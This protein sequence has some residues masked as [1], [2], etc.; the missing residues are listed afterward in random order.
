[1]LAL[2]LAATIA[3]PLFWYG[4]VTWDGTNYPSVNVWGKWTFVVL[5]V[6][7]VSGLSI[8]L[9]RAAW[10]V[11][12]PYGKAWRWGVAVT[13]AIGIAVTVLPD[14]ITEAGIAAPHAAGLQP[15][16]LFDLFGSL[17]FLLDWLL[18]LL[19]LLVALGLPTSPD[20]R[21][22]ARIL[23]I[24]IA[25]ELF[26]WNFTWLYLP[27]EFL[28]GILLVGWV[29]LPADLASAI[30]APGGSASALRKAITRWQGAEF[31]AGQR[32]GLAASG[33]DSLRDLLLK[34]DKQAYAAAL[35][36]LTTG[37]QE[38]AE[39]RA[40]YQRDALDAKAE[41][42][43]RKGAPLDRKGARTGLIT[44]ALLGV[45][46]ATVTLITTQP[47]DTGSA[48]PVLN[49]FGGTAWSVAVWSLDGCFIG[50]FLPLIRG[51]N[52]VQKALWMFAVAVTAEL[53]LDVIWD[54]SHAWAS[55]LIG[56]LEFLVFM[57]V[58]TVILDD[59][60]V[61][62]AAGMRATDWTRVHNWRFVVTWSTAVIAAIGT[63]AATFLSTA[64]TDFSH[65]TVTVITKQVN[66]PAG[67]SASPG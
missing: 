25:V 50:Y 47:A 7:T 35:S 54:D 40:A 53:P 51:A 8:M 21:P 32:Q 56:C 14:A 22:V 60:T 10:A 16:N 12:E 49:F 57:I 38:L 52:G 33:T 30:A 26:Y 28:L 29:M 13:V 66:P 67:K 5:A 59:L 6:V 20:P 37:Q 2:V 18:T 62:K 39:Q 55:S 44:G 48:Y 15:I 63:A 41:A 64:A 11:L 58:T 27:V 4:S 46:P 42:F 36:A 23:A 65:Q 34:N 19:L 45:I 61:L 17:P 1:M 9:A 31:I 24:P 3:W 43:S